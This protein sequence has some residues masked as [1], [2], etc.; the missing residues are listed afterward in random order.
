MESQVQPAF[1]GSQ[2]KKKTA[3]SCHDIPYCASAD[4]AEYSKVSEENVH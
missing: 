4:S 3:F 1:S 2:K